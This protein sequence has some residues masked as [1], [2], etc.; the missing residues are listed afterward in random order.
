MVEKT[1]LDE[2]MVSEGIELE[3][4]GGARRVERERERNGWRDEREGK[5]RSESGWN[6]VGKV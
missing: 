1:M 4:G 6:R 3:L 2:M 5:Q